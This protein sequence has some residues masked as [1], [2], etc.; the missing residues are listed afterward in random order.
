VLLIRDAA[1]H[2]SRKKV[3]KTLTLLRTRRAFFGLGDDG[4]FH[5]EDCAFVSGIIPESLLNLSNGFN[6]SIAKLLAKSNAITLLNSFR[7]FAIIDN[8]P[9]AHNTYAIIDL[10]PATDAVCER[11]KIHACA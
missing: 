4:R 7:H 3:N 6:L 10:L 2:G 9:S 5:C 1:P 8:P 11:E